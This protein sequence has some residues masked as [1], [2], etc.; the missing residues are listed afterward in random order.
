MQMPLAD[1]K[2]ILQGNLEIKQDMATGWTPMLFS[3]RTD[4][5]KHGNESTCWLEYFAM[6]ADDGII[7]SSN[8]INPSNVSQFQSTERSGILPING[9]AVITSRKPDSSGREMFQITMHGPG[10]MSG[11]TFLFRCTSAEV[12][13]TWLEALRKHR[14]HNSILLNGVLEKRGR[15]NVAWRRRLLVLTRGP[16]HALS[17]YAAADQSILRPGNSVQPYECHFRGC[18]EIGPET[19]VRLGAAG[20]AGAEFDVAGSPSGRVLSLRAPSAAVRE[21]WTSALR[22]LVDPPPPPIAD[23]AAAHGGARKRCRDRGGSNDPGSRATGARR[24][25]AVTGPTDR[26]T[27]SLPTIDER[28]VT[29]LPSPYRCPLSRASS[30]ATGAGG[31][32]LRLRARRDSTVH[33]WPEATPS[34]LPSPYDRPLSRCGDAD[35][36]LR[37]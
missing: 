6:K 26:P 20:P 18:L 4:E 27:H 34:S 5:R 11:K 24:R 29:P 37:L 13:S 30:F 10:M 2:I 16:P 32:A 33:K 19:T 28:L 35:D 1:S 17:Y 31:D 12:K 36:S 15:W 14:V 8:F 25:K 3:L 9:S 21:H 23:A 7:L 22:E